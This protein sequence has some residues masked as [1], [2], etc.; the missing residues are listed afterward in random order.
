MMRT[1]DSIT[2]W[3]TLRKSPIFENKSVGFVPTMGALHEGHGSLLR[4]SRQAHDISVLSIFVNPTQFNDPNDLLHYPRDL[5]RDLDIAKACGTDFVFL[6]KAEEIYL[7]KFRFNIIETEL[8]NRLCGTHRPG[9]F[10]GVLSVVM[11]LFNLIRPHKSYFGEKD[12]QQYLLVKGM[13]DAFFM[14]LEI[15]CCPT[16]RAEDGLALS[17]RNALLS[18][19]ERQKSRLFPYH[20]R[21]ANKLEQIRQELENVGFSVD[22]LEEFEGRRLGAVRI[23]K[24]RLIDNVK[25]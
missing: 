25:I 14:N 8:A 15:V 2:D 21:S 23:G 6:P 4:R 17:S 20:L 1:I 13:V 16:I 12:Y 10:I 18:A 7:D 5:K 11:K 24:V 9:H 19:E 3:Q 22:Y